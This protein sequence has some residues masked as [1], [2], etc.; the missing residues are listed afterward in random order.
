[1]KL[2][3]AADSFKGSLDARSA[4]EAIREGVLQAR[5][6][7]TVAVK[8]MADGGEGTAA[9]VMAALGGEWVPVR[10]TGPLESMEVDAGYAWFPHHD[11]TALV[12]MAAANGLTLL[13]PARRNPLLTTTFGTGELI[14]AAAVQGARRILLAV[15]GSATVDG[16][17]GAAAA[18]GWR[19]LDDAGQPV[20][21][22]GGE[23]ER[24][25]RI[26]LPERAGLPPVEVLCDVKNPLCGERGAAHVFAPQKGASREAVQR[27]E[28]GLEHLARLIETTLGKDLRDLPGGGAAGGLAAGAVAFMNATLTSGIERLIEVSGLEQDL[29]G[30]DWVVTGEGCF[31]EPSLH[32]KVVSGVAVA[33]R[34]AGARVAVIAGQVRLS[35]AEWRS[36]GIETATALTGPGVTTDEAVRRAQE[37]LREAARRWAAAR[38]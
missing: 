19:F 28:R 18:L 26:L 29:R 1:M 9:A 36:A 35:E 30:A 17:A 32:G 23:L 14:R 11:R 16:G 21:P 13:P 27:L 38:S 25:A 22:G 4:C 24:I 3:A 7:W 20:G 10:V 2:V 15:G 12:E 37:L 31:D 6:D 33:A 5:P 34:R 8:P